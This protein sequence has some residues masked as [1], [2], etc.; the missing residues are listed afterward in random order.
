[1]IYMKLEYSC[2]AC[3]TKN[4]ISALFIS[5]RI[6]LAKKLGK[7][8]EHRCPH[9]GANNLV[10]VDDVRA[11]KDFTFVLLAIVPVV[12]VILEL[13]FLFVI[14]L[15]FKVLHG[16]N[17]AL[18]IGPLFTVKHQYNKIHQFNMMYYDSSR[19]RK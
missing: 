1:M 5:N 13:L 2:P 18:L 12:A 3:Q 19:F 4:K 14:P 6:D 17:G 9:C 11:E 16:V 8:F 7:E 10:H 15:H